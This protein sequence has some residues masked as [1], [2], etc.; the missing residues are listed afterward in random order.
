MVDPI[1]FLALGKAHSPTILA[2]PSCGLKL[3]PT[4]GPWMRQ[5]RPKRLNFSGHGIS[6][7]CCRSQERLPPPYEDQAVPG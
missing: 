4:R 5:M 1:W 6:S 2:L 7:L 3:D